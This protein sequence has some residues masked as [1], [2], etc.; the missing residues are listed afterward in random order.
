M[1]TPPG[2]TQLG[3]TDADTGIG[4]SDTLGEGLLE[5]ETEAAGFADPLFF[6]AESG[7]G[8]D[9]GAD[10][11]AFFKS[12]MPTLWADGLGGE[13]QAASKTKPRPSAA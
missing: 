9:V 13:P 12:L 5:G 11:A 7:L 1:A 4:R 6:V 8:D 2:L 10:S 3:V